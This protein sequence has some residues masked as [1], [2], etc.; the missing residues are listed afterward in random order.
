LSHGVAEIAKPRNVAPSPKIAA[1]LRAGIALRVG[2]SIVIEEVTRRL[3]LRCLN[4][5]WKLE[6][7][8]LFWS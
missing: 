8:S 3:S 2:L 4:G 6:T 5:C 1:K 7:L